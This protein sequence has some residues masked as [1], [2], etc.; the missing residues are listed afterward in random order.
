MYYNAAGSCL[1]LARAENNDSVDVR[2]CMSCDD[3]D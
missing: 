2:F 3:K 1:Y